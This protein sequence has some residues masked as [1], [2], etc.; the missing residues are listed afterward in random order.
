MS[1]FCKKKAGKGLLSVKI[2]AQSRS[3][4]NN[5][6]TDEGDADLKRRSR[7]G[8]VSVGLDFIS[9]LLFVGKKT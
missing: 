5:W 2:V 3:K 7:L 8:L 6:S 4:N 1:L 9:Y